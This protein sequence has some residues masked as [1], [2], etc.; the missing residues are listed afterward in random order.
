MIYY[1]RRLLLTFVTIAFAYAWNTHPVVAAFAVATALLLDIFVVSRSKDL[2]LY[3]RG[4]DFTAPA[5]VMRFREAAYLHL[6]A[7]IFGPVLPLTG[8]IL[9]VGTTTQQALNMAAIVV[10]GS[11]ASYCGFLVQKGEFAEPQRL[12]YRM[13]TY[14]G[15]FGLATDFLP[16]SP[17]A[18]LGSLLRFAS[19]IFFM[20]FLCFMLAALPA[21]ELDVKIVLLTIATAALF[22][23]GFLFYFMALFGLRWWRQPIDYNPPPPYSW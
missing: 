21:L 18:F 2:I 14:T 12:L 20:L 16:S 19:G 4:L 17:R 13:R 10:C 9:N 8:R 1:V 22:Q 5:P 15:D 11:V 23:A 3:R 6:A 7:A